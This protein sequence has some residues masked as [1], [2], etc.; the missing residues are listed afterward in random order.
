MALSTIAAGAVAGGVAAFRPN[1]APAAPSLPLPPSPADMPEL[2]DSIKLG[3][4]L[5]DLQFGPAYGDAGTV[6]V[7]IES[8]VKLDKQKSSGKS[9]SKTKVNGKDDIKGKLIVTGAGPS[10]PSFCRFTMQ[11]DPQGPTGGSPLTT[12][13]PEF[14]R[15]TGSPTLGQSA[16]AQPIKIIIKKAGKLKRMSGGE[17]MWSQEFDFEEWVKPDDKPGTTDTPGDAAHPGAKYYSVGGTT[18]AAGAGAAAA[19]QFG[20]VSFGG[21]TPPKATP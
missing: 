19:A 15:R 21:A 2:W 4:L 3:S 17:G 9:K 20:K 12:D 16:T 7:E 5:G 11:I 10:W 14:M 8:A 1:V 6:V 18:E 13:H